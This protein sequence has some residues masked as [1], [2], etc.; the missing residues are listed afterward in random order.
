MLAHDPN[1]LGIDC[2]GK[3]RSGKGRDGANDRRP[4]SAKCWTSSKV[5]SWGVSCLGVEGAPG[6]GVPGATNS[7]SQLFFSRFGT[8]M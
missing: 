5:T 1:P 2:T 4:V 8:L 6:C 3:G 7:Q